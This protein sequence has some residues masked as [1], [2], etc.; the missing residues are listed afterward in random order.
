MMTLT[1][2]EARKVSGGNGHS[3]WEGGCL[4][5]AGQAAIRG[6]LAGG[7][8]GGIVGAITGLPG[9]PAGIV[10]GAAIG[11]ARGAIRGAAIEGVRSYANC[12]SGN[13]NGGGN[14]RNSVG[15]GQC[16]W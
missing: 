15:I 1:Y 12:S 11:Y 4:S 2:E 16:T 10:T 8:S 6:G 5:K 14:S 3:N 7:I 13:S 9:G